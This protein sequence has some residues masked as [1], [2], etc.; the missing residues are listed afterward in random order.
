MSRE[1]E[2]GLVYIT[3]HNIEEPRTKIDERCAKANENEKTQIDFVLCVQAGLL[4]LAVLIIVLSGGVAAHDA[5]TSIL[6][7]VDSLVDNLG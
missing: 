7:T 1:R 3:Q 6:V 4:S 2:R 5:N